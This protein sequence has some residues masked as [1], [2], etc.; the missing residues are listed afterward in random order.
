M[1]NNTH[2]TGGGSYPS[3]TTTFIRITSYQL[4][5]L[6]KLRQSLG[7]GVFF[8]SFQR[9]SLVSMIII[10]IFQLGQLVV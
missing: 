6:V 3:H 4:K 8:A 2:T 1:N 5:A 9:T 10:K 7:K